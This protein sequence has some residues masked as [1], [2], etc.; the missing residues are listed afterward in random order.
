MASTT[1]D[2]RVAGVQSP[3][4]S[5]GFFGG[6]AHALGQAYR[7]LRIWQ[8]RREQRRHMLSLD[9]RLLRDIGLSR[10]QAQMEADKPFWRA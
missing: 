1:Y 4:A 5:R 3:A 9:D 8:E 2:S 7:T 6:I 10:V